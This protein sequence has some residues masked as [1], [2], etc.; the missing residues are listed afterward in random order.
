MEV[1]NVIKKIEKKVG[2]D[3]VGKKKK[4]VKNKKLMLEETRL[5]LGEY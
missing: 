2:I 3:D 1:K 4:K 5:K